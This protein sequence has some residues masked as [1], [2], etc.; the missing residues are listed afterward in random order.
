M[1]RDL[2]DEINKKL[3]EDIKNHE[4][5]KK[6]FAVLINDI[7]NLIDDFYIKS[8][9]D[10]D[11]SNEEKRK[12]GLIYN[13]KI[14]EMAE[15]KNKISVFRDYIFSYL[16]SCILIRNEMV[17]HKKIYLFY[18]YMFNMIHF[19]ELTIKFLCVSNVNGFAKTDAT[20][21]LLLLYEN[22]KNELLSL[23][24]SE[25]YYI[26]LIELL[27]KIKSMIYTNDFAMGFK[28]PVNKDFETQIILDELINLKDVNSVTSIVNEQKTLLLIALDIYFL[29]SSSN[30]RN[31]IKILRDKFEQL[32]ILFSDK[33]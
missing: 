9:D 21:N 8:I 29:G 2:E 19:L 17:L 13:N 28:Y 18:S 25:D 1:V 15:E 32:R 31:L 3:D 10:K 16:D 33:K 11:L 30:Y 5:L 20:H 12:L 6:E 26:I 14:K 23:G 27:N 4:K 24:I 22:R 7:D